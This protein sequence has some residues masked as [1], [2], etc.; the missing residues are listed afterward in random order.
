MLIPKPTV[1]QYRNTVAKK[2]GQLN[3]N[4]A[5]MAPTWNNAM[6]MLV[7]QL[8]GWSW[9]IFMISELTSSPKI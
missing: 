4:N 5:A 3:M 2:T 9:L 7:G 1:T 6:V 8:M